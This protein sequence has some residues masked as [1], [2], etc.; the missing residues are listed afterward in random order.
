MA[1]G[2]SPRSGSAV[3]HDRRNPC[4]ICGGHADLP[5]G[6]G[7][8]CAGVTLDKVTYCTREQFAG[9]LPIEIGMSPPAYKHRLFGRCDCGHQHGMSAIASRPWRDVAVAPPPSDIAPID[10]RDAVYAFALD[11]LP[12]RRAALE[13]LQRRELSADA[14][15]RHRFRSL[16]MR[17]SEHA[18]FMTQMLA[19]FGEK[20]L[21]RVPGFT[22][23]NRRF[24][25]RTA[26]SGRD[27]YIIPYRDEMGRVT[28]FQIRTLGHADKAK[29]LTPTHA[30]LR[31]IYGIA[32]TPFVGCMVHVTEGGLKGI[33]AHELGGYIT[34][35]VAGQALMPEHIDAIRRLKPAGVMVALDREANVSTDR[36]RERWLRDLLLAGI[37]AVE[38]VWEG[39]EVG[40]PKGLDDLLQA[41]GAPR[42]RLRAFAPPALGERRDVVRVLQHAVV[43]TLDGTCFLCDQHLRV[44][45]LLS[46]EQLRASCGE[47]P[48]HQLPIQLALRVL[49]L[50]VVV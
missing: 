27:G 5:S 18:E 34:F 45:D 3:R 25:F 48:R 23:K 41:F 8:R 20:T 37:P 10:V 29:Y 14:I 11:L 35:A 38:G 33:V 49:Q 7:I 19:R 6:R 36:A 15:A 32:G 24:N 40:G 22:D 46:A 2:R 28:G 42:E 16:P 47:E 39:S 9:Q 30:V 1:A 31:E 50:V 17:G 12:L 13:D 44:E 26:G 4:P 43:D 21:S